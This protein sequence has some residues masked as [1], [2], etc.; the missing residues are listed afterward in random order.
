MSEAGRELR[1]AFVCES[2]LTPAFKIT[3]TKETNNQ[4]GCGIIIIVGGRMEHKGHFRSG[5]RRTT[6]MRVVLASVALF[7]IF[8]ARSTPSQFPDATATHSIGADSHH[9]QRPRFDHG[10]LS[11]SAPAAAFVLFPPSAEPLH[12]TPASQVTSR[13]QTKGFHFNRPPPLS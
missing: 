13:L 5:T 9:E 11:W 1:P 7:A 2:S 8:A 4:N 6:W 3:I 10:T 12:L